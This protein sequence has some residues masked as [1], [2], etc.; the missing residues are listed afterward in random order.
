[1]A[2]IT[3][4]DSFLYSYSIFLFFIIFIIGMGASQYFAGNIANLT[5]PEPQPPVVTGNGFL[6]WFTNT[7]NSLGYFFS[8]IGFFFTLMSVDTGVAWVGSIIFSPAIVFLAY[9]LLRLV[10]GGG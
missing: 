7:G 1:M 10:R 9:G 5:P 4:F 8:N 6:D 3:T 2:K